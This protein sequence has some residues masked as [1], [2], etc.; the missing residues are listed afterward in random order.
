M[1]TLVTFYYDVYELE[2]GDG[3]H[4]LLD[5]SCSSMN[6]IEIPFICINEGKKWVQDGGE[7]ILGLDG[8]TGEILLKQLNDTHEINGTTIYSLLGRQ[9]YPKTNNRTFI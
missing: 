2:H 1:R 5:K 9:L 6:K 8:N 7:P 3:F 4:P